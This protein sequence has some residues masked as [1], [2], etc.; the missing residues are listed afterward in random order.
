MATYLA[1]GSPATTASLRVD[2]YTVRIAKIYT[3]ATISG[4]VMTV[5][6]YTGS[7]S[8]G[9]AATPNPL[10]TGAPGTACTFK[11][12]PTAPGGL[13]TLAMVAGAEFTPTFDLLITP[14]VVL[15]VQTNAN[16][17]IGIYYEEQRQLS[18]SY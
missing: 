7:I 8:G 5:S 13:T 15:Y 4:L 10:R 16:A 3:T 9:T 12:N 11:S 17:A 6:K 2:T 14:G 18:W 1:F